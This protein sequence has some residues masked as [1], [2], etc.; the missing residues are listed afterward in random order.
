MLE[1]GFVLLKNG[2]FRTEQFIGDLQKEWQLTIDKVEGSLESFVLYINGF[3]CVFGLM[4]AP[5]PN[6]EAQERAKG[7]YY[8][9]DAVQIATEHEAHLMVTVA[10]QNGSNAQATMTLYS[11]LIA[12]CLKQSN[13]IGVYT[14]GT[15]YGANFYRQVTQ[16]YLPNNQIPVMIWVYIGLGQTKDGN[17]LYTRGMDKFGKDD[18]EIL[19]SQVDMKTLHSSLTAMCGYII[20]SDLTLQDGES[21]GFSAEQRWQITKSKSVYASCDESLKIEIV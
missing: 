20:S 17:Q 18:M 11:K 15:V 2:N 1:T 10:N 9:P 4:P 21:I 13:A 7:N 14:T 16:Q 8:C 12:T 3:M 6:Q 5:I 19:N